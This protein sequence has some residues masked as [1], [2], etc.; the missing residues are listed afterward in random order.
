[1]TE[2]V[3]D[4]TALVHL[5]E[6]SILAALAVRFQKK[7]IYTS[8]GSILVAINP[9]EALP[10]LYSAALKASYIEHGDRV[11]AGEKREKLPPHVYA[12]ADKAFRDLLRQTADQSVL[13]SGESGAGKT[14]TTKIIMNYLASVSSATTNDTHIP[15]REN[16]RNRV[17]ESNPILE[18]FGNA[19]T[20]RNNN[21]SRFGKFIRLGFDRSGSLLGASISTYLLER[22]RLVSQ[23]IGERNYHIFYELLRGATPDELAAL[24]LTRI[25]DYKY[26]NQT[27]CVDRKDGVDDG[28]QYTKTRHA[29]TTIGMADDEQWSVLQVVAAILHLG[30]LEFVPA[31]GGGATFGQSVDLVT[32]CGLLGV[33]RD[34]LQSGLCTRKIRAGGETITVPLEPSQALGAKDVVGKALYAQLFE[35]LV[36][37][38]N[39]SMAYEDTSR[40][41]DPTTSHASFI[42]I[43]DI[44]GFEIFPTNS[45][46]QLCINYANEKLQQLFS[47]F[48]FAMEQDEYASQGIPWTFVEYPNNDLQCMLPK[49]G[50]GPFAKSLYDL[51]G[52]HPRFAASKLQ[53]GSSQFS[54]LHYAGTV[55]YIT[56]GFCDKNKDHVHDE[57][58]DM[59]SASTNS[60]VATLFE[61][62]Q[63]LSMLPPSRLNNDSDDKPRRSS[64]IMGATV[65]MKFKQQL[66][67]LLG[68]L[69]ATS[70]H[71]VRCIKPNDDLQ[72]STLDEP[73]VREQ[74]QCSGILEAVKI[75]R[76][77]YAVR[78]PHEAFQTEFRP[79]AP[80]PRSVHAMLETL[81]AKYALPTDKP[82]FQLGT[83]KVFVVQAAFDVLQRERVLALHRRVVTLQAFARMVLAR[84]RF[85]RQQASVR[86]IQSAVRLWRFRRQRRAAAVVLQGSYRRHRAQQLLR[87]LRVAKAQAMAAA[88]KAKADAA[89][90]AKAVAEAARRHTAAAAE[91]ERVAAQAK[92]I[93]DDAY[94]ALNSP[95][96]SPVRPLVRPFVSPVH[97]PPPPPFYP[98]VIGDEDDDASESE[99]ESEV[100][101]SLANKYEIT[102]PA[103][104]LGLYFG[105][106]LES[107]LPVVQRVHANLSGCSTISHV[108]VEDVLVSVGTKPIVP[109]ASLHQTL[110]YMHEIAK[111][112]TLV[113][114][115][116]GHT[117]AHQLEANE[118][119]VLW[120]Y[121][122]PL[123]LHF[124]LHRQ[125][126]LPYV[127]TILSSPMPN[128]PLMVCKGDLLTHVNAISTYM[129]SQKEINALLSEQPKPCVLRFRMPDDDAVT[130]SRVSTASSGRRSSVIALNLHKLTPNDEAYNITWTDE[131]GPLGLVVTPLLNYY[132]EVV[133][134]KDEGAAHAMRQRGRVTAG[135]MLIAINQQDISSMGFQHAMHVLKSSP[136]PLVLTLQRSKSSSSSAGRSSLPGQLA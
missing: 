2:D 81:L 113:F 128:E 31:A 59:L 41:I 86:T 25:E 18:A 123:N 100:A 27:Q 12:V 4:L 117:P 28:D 126:H 24:R 93:A 88:A 85:R 130:E 112:V 16:V 74:L 5:D 119:E 60:F 11:M 94:R 96:N 63:V 64:G 69:N 45:L 102:W 15:E 55:A 6:A 118:Y 75:S 40:P 92:A 105:R 30:N 104:M 110:A 132:I 107:G 106:D 120:G 34:R 135:D 83:S 76:L 57:A 79:L 70:P 36:D 29:M 111:P 136:K 131:D 62:Y 26:L 10:A 53:Q 61:S 23:S 68:V 122:E 66:T 42:G 52:K 114:Q 51:L 20:N 17:L 99:T 54:V 103:G 84:T 43:V 82:P 78:F 134:V 32:L 19:R 35:W 47:Q 73:R 7:A 3:A 87:T 13:V 133:K 91:A 95:V 38:I 1:M 33:S 98:E 8:T 109:H 22:V 80:G 108:A 90:K 14:E 125:R 48:V 44:F 97:A 115:R 116:R 72:P 77:G 50:D 89:A 71:F 101:V 46:E 21:S 124:K 127:S 65:A 56:D 67:D 121:N 129:K 39:E 49:G 9:F 37:R 58:I